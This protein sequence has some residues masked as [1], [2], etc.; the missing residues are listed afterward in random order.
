MALDER[1]AKFKVAHWHQRKPDSATDADFVPSSQAPTFSEAQVIE[2]RRAS[3]QIAA[4]L[5]KRPSI[6]NAMTASFVAEPDSLN[7]DDSSS[8]DEGENKYQQPKQAGS[9]N[10]RKSL[11][12]PFRNPNSGPK[13]SKDRVQSLLSEQFNKIDAMEFGGESQQTDVLEVWFA[14]AHADVGGGAV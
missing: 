5:A 13:L 2:Q 1:R 3:A 6:S 4:A 8:G 10:R 11:P 12:I 9:P 14:G 7:K